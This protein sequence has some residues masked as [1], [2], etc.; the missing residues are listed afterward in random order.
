MRVYMIVSAD[1]YEL[2]LAVED[3]ADR[4][5][6]ILGITR[7]AV[8]VTIAR[9]NVSLNTFNGCKYRIIKVDIDEEDDDG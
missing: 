3:S 2:P 6:E 8:Y 4:I 1:E 7:N 9:K 5:A